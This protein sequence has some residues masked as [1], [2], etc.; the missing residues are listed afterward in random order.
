MAATV[1]RRRGWIWELQKE[2]AGRFLKQAVVLERDGG[3]A[4][5]WG[6]KAR[7]TLQDESG[8]RSG[9]SGGK[10]AGMPRRMFSQ[11]SLP[12]GFH[13]QP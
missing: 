9:L 5:A 3:G 7:P 10:A 11:S 13:P 4:A 2:F 6:K 1:T 8:E 12:H